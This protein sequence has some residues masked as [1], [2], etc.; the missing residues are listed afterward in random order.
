M[1]KNK[2]GSVHAI[3]AFEFGDRI[4]SIRRFE[5]CDKEVRSTCQCPH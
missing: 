5:E 2:F 4:F 3:S 1:D